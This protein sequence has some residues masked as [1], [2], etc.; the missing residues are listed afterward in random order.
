[1]RPF[2]IYEHP[3]FDSDTEGDDSHSRIPG[4]GSSGR[5]VV[6]VCVVFTGVVAILLTLATMGIVPIPSTLA[7]LGPKFMAR[8]S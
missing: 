2:N 3:T 7:G 8:R 6:S 4:T 1:M 5:N